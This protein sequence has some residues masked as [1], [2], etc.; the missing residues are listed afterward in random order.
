MVRGPFGRLAPVGQGTEPLLVVVDGTASTALEAPI[1]H[2]GSGIQGILHLGPQTRSKEDG[3]EHHP[4][5][6]E[7]DLLT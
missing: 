6:A 4:T 2:E 5:E 3:G 1:L 7:A